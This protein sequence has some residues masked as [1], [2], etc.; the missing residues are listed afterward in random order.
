MILL[1]ANIIIDVVTQREGFLSSVVLLDQIRK[2][3]F[4]A[5]ISPITVTNCWYI[6]STRVGELQSKE[7]IEKVIKG[8]KIAELNESIIQD[9]FKHNMKDFEDLIQFYTAKKLNCNVIIT[10]NVKDFNNISNEIKIQTPEE[11]LTDEGI[12][13]SKKAQ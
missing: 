8:I 3:K 6:I 10:R 7:I 4:E 5:I 1:D 12:P 9:A 2:G 11:F 13:W